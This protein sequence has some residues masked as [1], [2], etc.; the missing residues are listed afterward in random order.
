MFIA[1]CR[2]SV[3]ALTVS[4]LLVLAGCSSEPEPDLRPA[5]PGKPQAKVPSPLAGQDV[6]FDGQILA[7]IRVGP[8]GVPLTG[9][10]DKGGGEHGSHGGRLNMHGSGG[11]VAGSIS[12][13]VPLGSGGHSHHASRPQGG[14]ETGP[15][16]KPAGGRPVMIHLRFTNQGPGM[17]TLRIEDF[18][19]PYGNFAVRP[20]ELVLEPGQTLET[21]P[22]TSEL[23]GSSE[24]VE[25]TLKLKL[26]AKMEKKSFLLRAS[27]AAPIPEK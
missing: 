27:P 12:G 13:S 24:E 10:P 21:D 3:A 26:G 2:H 5:P 25:A 22:M 15:G 8:D 23:A 14:E 1:S 16:P 20:E 6:F 19:S 18:A 4:I 7:A 11:E 17:A 9:A